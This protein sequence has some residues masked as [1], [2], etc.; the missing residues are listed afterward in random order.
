MA[1]DTK[2]EFRKPEVHV[3]RG[4]PH[5]DLEIW[6][7]GQYHGYVDIHTHRVKDDSVSIGVTVRAPTK[8][9]P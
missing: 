5:L 6:K 3:V 9:K 4:Q 1:L 8:R 7:D 2:W